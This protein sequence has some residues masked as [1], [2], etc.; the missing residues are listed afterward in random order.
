MYLPF[1]VGTPRTVTIFITCQYNVFYLK[2]VKNLPGVTFNFPTAIFLKKIYNIYK[3][4]KKKE[5]KTTNKKK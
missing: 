2:K 5:E 1:E 3:K 4:K